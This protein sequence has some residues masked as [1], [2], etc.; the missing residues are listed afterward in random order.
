MILNHGADLFAL[1]SGNE[2]VLDLA[3]NFKNKTIAKL[4]QSNFSENYE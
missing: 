1:T 3:L 2:S 4:I